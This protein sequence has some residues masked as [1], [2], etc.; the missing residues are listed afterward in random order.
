MPNLKISDMVLYSPIDYSELVPIVQR[1]ANRKIQLGKLFPEVFQLACSDRSSSLTTASSVASFHAPFGFVLT[2]AQS[3][4]LVASSSG[5]VSVQVKK[6]G[7]SLLSTVL[8]IDASEVSSLTAAT[9]GVI[10]GAP[11]IVQGDLITIDITASGTG[12]KGLI[13]TL[14]GIRNKR[15]E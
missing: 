7:T 4:V 13:V 11:S 1:G 2:D 6:N 10:A 15:Y 9:P 14:L 5:L 12:A 8:S 3:E